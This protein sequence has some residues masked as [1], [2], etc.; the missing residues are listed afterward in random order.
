[1]GH[2]VD[3]AEERVCQ[4]VAVG[5]LFENV[6]ADKLCF[7]LLEVFISVVPQLITD[8]ND[9]EFELIDLTDWLAGRIVVAIHWMVLVILARTVER[10]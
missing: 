4:R 1:M 6:R 5:L 7:Q 2:T 3:A 9:H 10:S 8:S